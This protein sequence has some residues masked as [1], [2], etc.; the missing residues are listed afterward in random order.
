MAATTYSNI[1]LDRDLSGS[2]PTNTYKALLDGDLHLLEPAIFSERSLT[3]KLHV[4]KLLE[5]VSNT[6][7]FSG[8]KYKLLLTAAEKDQIAA[9]VGEIVYFMPHRRDEGDVANYRFV[10]LFRSMQDVIGVDPCREYF[11]ATVELESADDN[12]V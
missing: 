9:D 4:H 3:G 10:M 11:Y 12:E 6:K 5:D 7:V 1:R 8:R 2:L